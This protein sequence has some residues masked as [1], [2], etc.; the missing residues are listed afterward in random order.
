MNSSFTLY[1]A[2]SE[3]VI[4]KP[5]NELKF[6]LHKLKDRIALAQNKSDKLDYRNY[7]S[8][9][10]YNRGDMAIIDSVESKILSHS[11]NAKLTRVNWGNL[12]VKELQQGDKIL[13]CGSGYVFPSPSGQLPERMHRD[14]IVFE[15]P[16]TEKHLL[17]I[18]YNRLL[19]W[20]SNEKV[21]PTETQETLAAIIRACKTH[22]VRDKETARLLSSVSNFDFEVIGDPALFLHSENPPPHLGLNSKPIVGL[23]IPF[24]GKEPTMWL[25]EN[26][27]NLLN[28]IKEIKK[29]QGCNI[30]YFVHYD[31]ELAIAESLKAAGLVD[32]IINGNTVK[33]MA[34]YSQL[35]YHIGGM[36]HSCIMAT[37]AEVPSI[38]LA[39]D[40]KHFGFFELMNR[41]EYCI[42]ANPFDPDHL[43]ELANSLTENM[44]HEKQKIEMRKNQLETRYD[45]ILRS[46]LTQ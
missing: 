26:Y 7:Q 33:M 21:L 15:R 30:H 32:Q 19:D 5:I 34:A 41:N 29:R 39:Y 17:G 38:G 13:V 45:S 2:A 43:I 40:T 25:R 20:G 23:N 14:R 16:D 27:L 31:S 28:C 22:T 37:A 44:M 46:I 10:A 35:S 8:S 3:A 36:L 11:R 42:L 12:D 18:G 24:H 9:T 6:A 4:R 1:G